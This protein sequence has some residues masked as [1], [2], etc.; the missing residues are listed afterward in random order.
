MSKIKLME[1]K[2]LSPQESLDL[3]QSMIGKARQRYTD[4]SFH[5]LL[6]GWIIIVASTA[7]FYLLEFTD[8]PNPA[9]VW[10]LNF[11]GVVGSSIKGFRDGKQKVVTNYS[12]KVYGW[13]WLALGISMFI[14][15]LN[16]FYLNWQLV[17]Y[18]LIMVGIG[19]FVSGA[20]MH[21]KLLQLGG[22]I[23]WILCFIAFRVPESYQMLIMAGG[24]LLGYL[25][26]GYIMKFKAKR[27]GL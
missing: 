3:I 14:I 22:I 11:V 13:L 27:N 1:D 19:T 4:N 25:V 5:F 10:L 6:W 23:C 21:F 2:E 12:D 17:P 24:M 18:I 16:G 7:H 26:P 9:Y 20:M 15:V 8:Y